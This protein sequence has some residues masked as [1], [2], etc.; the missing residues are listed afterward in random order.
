MSLAEQI[1][2]RRQYVEN[3]FYEKI[4]KD[5][6]NNI[7]DELEKKKKQKELIE[8]FAKAD[9]GGLGKF[10]SY[11]ATTIASRVGDP[12]KPTITELPTDAKQLAELVKVSAV[13]EKNGIRGLAKAKKRLE[14]NSPGYTLDTE[15]STPE[16]IVVKNPQGKVTVAFRGTNPKATI[17]SGAG[18]GIPEP[19]MWLNILK[20][21]NEGKHYDQHNMEKIRDDLLKKYN[22]NDIEHI[23]GYSMGGTKAHRL[24]NLLKKDST[25]FNPL[26]GKRFFDKTDPNTTHQIYR[27]TE[28]IATTAG[29]LQ[30]KDLQSNVKIESID[31]VKK[32]QIDPKKVRKG[33]SNWEVFGLVDE[34]N[35][36]HFTQEGD[37]TSNV[38]ETQE[39]IEEK[40]KN[41]ERNKIGKSPEYVETLQRQLISEVEPHLK[42]LSQ[43][44]SYKYTPFQKM[45]RT[46]SGITAGNMAVGIGGSLIGSKAT[47]VVFEALEPL[48]LPQNEILESAVGGTL[49]QYTTERII[50]R[51]TKAPASLARSLAGGGGGAVVQEL[52]AQGTKE[53]F[54]RA[55]MD[56]EASE[57]LS[58]TIGGG[59]GGGAS[60][61]IPQAGARLSSALGSALSTTSATAVETA[62][63][64]MGA[65]GAESA[66][67]GTEALAVG[68]T[69]ALA[70]GGLETTA[71][72]GLET[73]GAEAV[74]ET[75]AVIGAEIV[76]E[77]V[78]ARGVG[79]VIGGVLGGPVGAVLIGSAVAGV[80][81][82]FQA[83]Q[84]RKERERIE[85]QRQEAIAQPFSTT[86]EHILRNN[87]DYFLAGGTKEQF[88]EALGENVS[89]LEKQRMET[90]L[91]DWID[92]N[93]WLERN[94]RAS[95][96]AREQLH[97]SIV[98]FHQRQEAEF[99]ELRQRTEMPD[100][101]ENL[102]EQDEEYNTTLNVN[103][104]NQRI[105]EIMREQAG[106]FDVPRTKEHPTRD[107]QE[108]IFRNEPSVPQ[109]DSQGNVYFQTITEPRVNHRV[110]IP[111]E[112]QQAQPAPQS[113]TQAT[114][115]VQ[116]NPQGSHALNVINKDERIMNLLRANDL[117]GVNKR[118]REIF[119]ENKDRGAWA[120]DT[121]KYGDAEL[122]QFTSSGQLQYQKIDKAPP[123]EEQ[124]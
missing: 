88:I 87:F 58:Q 81:G 85:G 73:L 97:Q 13:W 34:H 124:E 36:E 71:L 103:I 44:L 31:P 65:V 118:I 30:G 61:V 7:K 59:A 117:H 83:D 17:K 116:I 46:K 72:V 16:H 98:A 101:L 48:G 10:K 5:A 41:F 110:E 40:V 20:G 100:W 64:E 21:G 120:G 79:S 45:M 69:E 19:I 67:L 60:Y 25:T 80:V 115:Q 54:K 99:A 50:Q 42:V 74:A 62:G 55:G 35:L 113:A 68:G 4:D 11:G 111:P 56:E 32:H 112:A 15:L 92:N 22:I 106:D 53:L 82:I 28:D 29:L 95:I 43:D 104:K 9:F 26:V 96:V 39:I 94:R 24:A 63:I 51:F 2:R 119:T 49:G 1:H 86:E 12:L 107:L 33:R 93:V 123:T 102:L 109:F 76:G 37:R 91:Q 52:T 77:A 75:G 84:M 6:F 8:S 27:T 114:S 122:P 121:V 90:H 3:K 89:D 105:R 66:L 108:I 78:V 57:I 18:K 23:T 14:L 38:R 47:Q 70:V